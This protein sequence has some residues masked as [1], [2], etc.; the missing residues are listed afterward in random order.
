MWCPHSAKRPTAQLRM[1]P[2]GASEPAGTMIQNIKPARMRRSV[3]VWRSYSA[4]QHV[5]R[6]RKAPVG[7]SEPAAS[8][9]RVSSGRPQN[10]GS[11]TCY[12]CWIGQNF[13]RSEGFVTTSQNASICGIF[14][15]FSA[16]E[17]VAR[18]GAGKR[19][20]T[21]RRDAKKKKTSIYNSSRLGT[22]HHMDNQKRC[23][24]AGSMFRATP[25]GFSYLNLGLYHGPPW[26]SRSLSK[27]AGTNT[28][29]A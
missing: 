26:S 23:A 20:L 7:A 17:S 6:H 3:S 28:T 2:V 16:A 9:H 24:K 10:Q 13:V 27:A 15:W 22:R 18:S 21:S 5:A 4:K 11:A 14:R 12:L 1:A 8:A 29:S 25:Q 19:K